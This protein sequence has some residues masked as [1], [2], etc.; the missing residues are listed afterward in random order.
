[1]QFSLCMC[2][3]THQ[4]LSPPS[5][6]PTVD[7]HFLN[8]TVGFLQPIED[9]ITIS[10]ASR[11]F[12]HSDRQNVSLVCPQLVSPPLCFLAQS[13]SLSLYLTLSPS[14]VSK[15]VILSFSTSQTHP[16]QWEMRGGEI[17]GLT[18]CIFPELLKYAFMLMA[19]HIHKCALTIH[20]DVHTDTHLP[21]NSSKKTFGGR[22]G[23]CVHLFVCRGVYRQR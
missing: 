9:P 5:F 16:C 11:V 18:V 13:S 19:D 21:V 20:T 22:N 4:I 3:Q 10:F 14:F 2:H 7:G 17:T 1:M 8:A 6:K 15:H 23:W 12:A